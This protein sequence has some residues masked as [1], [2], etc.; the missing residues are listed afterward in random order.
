MAK[1]A[2]SEVVWRLPCGQRI[3]PDSKPEPGPDAVAVIRKANELIPP[4]VG[5]MTNDAQ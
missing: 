2:Y 1:R 3:A 4:Q 5:L